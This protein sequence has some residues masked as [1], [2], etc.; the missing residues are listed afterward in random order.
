MDSV[1]KSYGSYGGICTAWDCGVSMVSICREYPSLGTKIIHGKFRQNGGIGYILKPEKF[2]CQP[3]EPTSTATPAV[4][5]TP[6]ATKSLSTLAIHIISGQELPEVFVDPDSTKISKEKGY[7]VVIDLNGA[8]SDREDI[9]AK[10]LY[11][12]KHGRN[13]FWNEVCLFIYLFIYM[14]IIKTNFFFK[15]I[16]LL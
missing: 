5:V 9:Q 15:F 6:P 13:P 4:T 12:R 8:L 10:T 7:A 11:I 16:I 2:R 3:T 1:T 14:K